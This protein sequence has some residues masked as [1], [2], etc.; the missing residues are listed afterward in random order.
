MGVPREAKS[1]S[2]LPCSCSCLCLP[3][4][5]REATTMILHDLEKKL[6]VLFFILRDDG[7][8]AL[9][10]SHS[11]FDKVVDYLQGFGSAAGELVVL[12]GRPFGGVYGEEFRTGQERSGETWSLTDE[13][14]Q[15]LPRLDSRVRV[16]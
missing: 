12:S 5:L 8:V 1:Y 11:S 10:Q 13:V 3:P 4:G 6:S 16:Q 2:L 7:A 14:R 15:H 9:N